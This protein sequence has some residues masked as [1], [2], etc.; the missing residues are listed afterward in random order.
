[1]GE[2]ILFVLA[3][4]LANVSGW[5]A[6]VPYNR[7][8]A[9]VTPARCYAYLDN[10]LVK[11]KS[12][13]SCDKGNECYVIGEGNTNR[14]SSS[15]CWGSGAHLDCVICNT[16]CEVDSLA[17]CP[18]GQ[19]WDSATCQCKPSGPPQPPPEGCTYCEDYMG[20]AEEESAVGAINIQVP[21]SRMYHCS[22]C[23]KDAN[24]YIIS[25]FDCHEVRNSPGTC[26]QNG[27]CPSNQICADSTGDDSPVQC[28]ATFGHEVWM[29]DIKTCYSLS[30]VCWPQC[31][32]ACR[33]CRRTPRYS[34]AGFLHYCYSGCCCRYYWAYSCP[35]TGFYIPRLPPFALHVHKTRQHCI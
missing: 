31:G 18:E 9:G 19:E 7:T 34:R 11:C 17:G 24:G 8:W 16:K 6:C 28:I 32:L 14:P 13:L 10:P 20:W 26:S 4:L 35:H 29:K 12:Y 15:S 23:A 2:V 3:V 30:P 25:A 33:T 5:G 1:M 22:N 27:D 21:Y